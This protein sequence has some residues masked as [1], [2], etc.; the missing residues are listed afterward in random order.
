MY[1][2]YLSVYLVVHGQDT[3]PR[4]RA[5]NCRPT[6]SCCVWSVPEDGNTTDSVTPRG[7]RA[8]TLPNPELMLTNPHPC[9]TAT[10]TDTV[11]SVS[12]A[13]SRLLYD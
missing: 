5:E 12:V 13:V 4:V 9:V 7:F 3:W 10:A 6:S 1:N 2:L 11:Q 8:T